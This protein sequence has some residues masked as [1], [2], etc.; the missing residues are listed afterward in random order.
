MAW[1]SNE[2]G[3]MY[4]VDDPVYNTYAEELAATQA[5]T[6][7]ATSNYYDASANGGEGGQVYV[8]PSGQTVTTNNIG[9]P[10]SATLPTSQYQGTGGANSSEFR[11]VAGSPTST[12]IGGFQVGVET[13][14]YVGQNGQ[15]SYDQYGNPTT[16]RIQ[17][18]L[19]AFDKA[20]RAGTIGL[21]VAPWAYG[22]A[23]GFGGATSAAPET[24]A[25]TTGSSTLPT[26]G[27]GYSGVGLNPAVQTGGAGA[28]GGVGMNPAITGSTGYGLNATIPGI[29]SGLATNA[30]ALAAASGVPITADIFGGYGGL[31]AEQAYAL[32][33]ALTAADFPIGGGVP[34]GASSLSSALRQGA[35]AGLAPA[36]GKL[37]TGQTGMGMEIPGIVRTNQNPFFN[38]PQTPLQTPQKTEMSDLASLLR[39]G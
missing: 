3:E 36:L 22:A 35:T 9:Q 33:K 8:Y 18:E 23:T 16:L 13:P 20:M 25:A 26:V 17:P 15:I 30:G 31:T 6:A 32:D 7:G 34:S 11:P 19:S 38:T 24:F 2:N 10:T 14:T 39:K 37:A 4:Q 21:A 27:S 12:N 5:A 29:T 28:Y 1:L